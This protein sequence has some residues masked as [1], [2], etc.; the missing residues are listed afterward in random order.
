[1][2]DFQEVQE[3]CALCGQAP[4]GGKWSLCPACRQRLAE[5]QADHLAGMLVSD[6][7]G[8]AARSRYPERGKP[9]CPRCAKRF[10][11]LQAASAAADRDADQDDWR[12]VAQSGDAVGRDSRRGS[13]GRGQTSTLPLRTQ[14]RGK[15]KAVF[16]RKGPGR[17]G[18]G[19]EYT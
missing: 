18:S 13:A 14:Q 15:G 17:P 5:R 1:M 11:Q 12:P 16:Q 4:G 8:C 9:Y 6:C 19:Q 7:V 2:D 3:L 10:G